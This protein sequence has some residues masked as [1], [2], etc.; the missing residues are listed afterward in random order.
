ML[1][2]PQI[3]ESGGMNLSLQASFDWGLMW[4]PQVSEGLG[5]ARA[6]RFRFGG[7]DEASSDLMTFNNFSTVIGGSGWDAVVEE[8]QKRCG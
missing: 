2:M 7:W 3:A 4:R 8:W 5:G 1:L 6:I